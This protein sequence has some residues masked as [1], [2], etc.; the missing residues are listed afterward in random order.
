MWGC[1]QVGSDFLP[2]VTPPEAPW[3]LLELLQAIRKVMHRKPSCISK[4]TGDLDTGSSIAE[5]IDNIDLEAETSK[6]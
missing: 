6:I 2:I 3:V 4:D 1:C 5:R